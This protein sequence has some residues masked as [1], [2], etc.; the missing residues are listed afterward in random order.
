VKSENKIV[1][2]IV[3]YD[4]LANAVPCLSALS[5]PIFTDFEIIIIENADSAAFDRLA[6]A[7][8]RTFPLQL[9]CA[10]N[11]VVDHA[12]GTTIGSSTTVG[13]HS[14]LS[15]YLTERNNLLL[16]LAHFPLCY[17]PVV[18]ITFCLTFDDLIHGNRRVFA[19][20]W[21]GWCT[22]LRG[23]TERPTRV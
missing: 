3:F 20:A 11:T 18:L 5:H 14:S 2:A 19:T 22:G 13:A 9:G 12:Y 17:P 7:Q 10:H 8:Q 21:R 6:A 16:T 4:I 23:E 15:I 1:V